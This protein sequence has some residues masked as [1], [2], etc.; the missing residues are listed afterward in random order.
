[1]AVSFAQSRENGIL[2]VSKGRGI[3]DFGGRRAADR[4]CDILAESAESTGMPLL[5]GL[6]KKETFRA[7]IGL[8]IELEVS[9]TVYA[10]VVEIIDR[11]KKAN[12][13]AITQPK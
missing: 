10:N 8:L 12:T 11:T 9:E 7:N 4:I 3:M 6:F 5:G 1:M 2:G 13:N